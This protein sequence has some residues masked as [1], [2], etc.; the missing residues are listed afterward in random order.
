MERPQGADTLLTSLLLSPARSGVL[1]CG[2]DFGPLGTPPGGPHRRQWT[3]VKCVTFSQSIQRGLSLMKSRFY[4]P[5]S[6]RPGRLFKPAASD[7]RRTNSNL[8][9]RYSRN[10]LL[11]PQWTA[12]ATWAGCATALYSP[13]LNQIRKRACEY[14]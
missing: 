11:R 3:A 13:W 5:P 1:L 8:C 6:I 14:W 7:T 4:S 9:G 10:E 12:S 2:N